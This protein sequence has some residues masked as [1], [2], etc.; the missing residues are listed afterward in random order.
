LTGI[1]GIERGTSVKEIYSIAFSLYRRYL[2]E[3]LLVFLASAAAEWL[4]DQVLQVLPSFN[5]ISPTGAVGVVFPGLASLP[6]SLLGVA[7]NS[8][9]AALT[10]GMG[11]SISSDALVKGKAGIQQSFLSVKTRYL[12]LWLVTLL[13]GLLSVAGDAV[14]VLGLIF[15]IMFFLAIP[16]VLLENLGPIE[17][18]K[19]SVQL[20]KGQWV[21]IF[22]ILLIYGLILIVPDFVALYSS[23][24]VIGNIPSY[25]VFWLASPLGVALTTVV[26]YSSIAEQAPVLSGEGGAPLLRTWIAASAQEGTKTTSKEVSGLLVP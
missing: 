12:W 5:V 14:L 13:T 19:R 1:P 3:F 21:R 25:V 20:V 26:Y 8:P 24:S 17:G 6:Q 22:V 11:V 4:V 2:K 23:Q 15:G 18:M 10:S 7:L 16:A 9:V